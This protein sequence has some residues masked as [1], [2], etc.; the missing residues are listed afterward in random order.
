M[1]NLQE[2][3]KP[4][5]RGI[6]KLILS[7]L[8]QLGSLFVARIKDP[9]VKMMAQGAVSATGETIEALSDADPNDKDQIREIFNKLLSS[10]PFKEGSKAELLSKINAIEDTDTRVF[11]AALLTESYRIADILTD[12]DTQ[13]TE[14]MRTYVRELLR[15]EQ[16]MMMLR[17]MLGLLLTD[18]YAD[19][20]TLLIIQLLQTVL[21]EEGDTSPFASMLVELKAGYQK[22][23]LAA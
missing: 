18:A 8:T 9:E 4:R 10:G 7:L 21:E 19:T 2:D 15:S 3:Y 17:A 5:I 12:G 23:L 11:L 22:K 6:A 1:Q 16:G 13:N 20:A 14:Q